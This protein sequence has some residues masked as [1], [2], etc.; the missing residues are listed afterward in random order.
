MRMW[1]INPELLCR[2]HLLGEHLE[3]HMFLGCIKENKNIKGFIKNGLVEI[4]NIINRHNE[5]MN[6][7]IKRNWNHKSPIDGN[8]Q[9]ILWK[10]GF[11]DI[12]NNLKI[13]YNR[14]EKCKELQIKNNIQLK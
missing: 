10:E 3:M 6:E 14:C 8:L 13:L 1:N 9:N 4:N 7:M 5:I 11:V 2:Q 12:N